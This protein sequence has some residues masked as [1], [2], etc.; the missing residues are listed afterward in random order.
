MWIDEFGG[1]G[2]GK[3]T[4]IRTLMGRQGKGGR[5]G[6]VREDLQALLNAERGKGSSRLLSPKATE[7]AE[8]AS[9]PALNRRELPLRILKLKLKVPA[10]RV[11]EPAEPRLFQF[12]A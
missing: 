8:P 1:K 7:S 10:E 9:Q 6:R 12:P 2:E 3:E 5:V 11:V 4:K